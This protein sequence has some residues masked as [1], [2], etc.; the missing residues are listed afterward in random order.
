MK[1][2]TSVVYIQ[3]TLIETVSDELYDFFEETWNRNPKEFADEGVIAN[4]LSVDN[5]VVLGQK[6]FVREVDE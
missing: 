5:A 4:Q 1:E 6:I 2:I 3:A